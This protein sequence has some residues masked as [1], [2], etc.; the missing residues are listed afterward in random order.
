MRIFASM[1]GL[2]LLALIVLCGTLWG[3]GRCSKSGAGVEAIGA[4]IKAARFLLVNPE[5]V[6]QVGFVRR[7][8]SIGN[9]PERNDIRLSVL[10]VSDAR[11]YF[12]ERDPFGPKRVVFLANWYVQRFGAFSAADNWL[13]QALPVSLFVKERWAG[14]CFKADCLGWRHFNRFGA[15]DHLD[16]VRWSFSSVSVGNLR[17]DR[18]SRALNLSNQQKWSL[19]VNRGLCCPSTLFCRLNHLLSHRDVAFGG[20]GGIFSG[21]RIIARGMSGIFRSFGASANEGP[22]PERKTYQQNCSDGF[23]PTREVPPW[24]GLLVLIVNIGCA[25]LGGWCG[26]RLDSRGYRRSGNLAL[27]VGASLS[28]A[29]LIWLAWTFGGHA[30]C[31]A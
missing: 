7:P 24:A 20:N 30:S 3:T 10:W 17:A 5:E 28:L 15:G 2:L 26:G 19:H 18:A 1:T 29:S 16:D 12:F 9:T 25:A 14:R 21:P 6:S 8:A 4:S 13:D 31:G 23:Q 11:E 27:C 22:L